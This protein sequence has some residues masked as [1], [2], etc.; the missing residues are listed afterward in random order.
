MQIVW[1]SVDKSDD[2]SPNVVSPMTVCLMLVRLLCHFA[3]Y[4]E[5]CIG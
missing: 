2:G 4:R 1:E 3:K 5:T